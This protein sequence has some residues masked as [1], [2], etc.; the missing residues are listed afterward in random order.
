MDY[1]FFVFSTEIF[2]TNRLRS[3]LFEIGGQ[4]Y[5]KDAKISKKQLTFSGLVFIQSI[6]TKKANMIVERASIF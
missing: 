3:L 2:M 4:K 1:H 5:N 6:F